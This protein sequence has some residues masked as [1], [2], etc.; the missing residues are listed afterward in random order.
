VFSTSGDAL[1]IQSAD[2][3]CRNANIGSILEAAFNGGASALERDELSFPYLAPV[4]VET[5]QGCLPK[6]EGRKLKRRQIPALI[7]RIAALVLVAHP[8]AAQSGFYFGGTVAADS[9]DRGSM[10]LRTVPAAGGLV[11]WRFNDSW[12]IEF[13]LD[14]GLAE[15]DPH[16]RIGFFGTDTLKDY[17][18]EGF[19]VLATWKSRPLGRV[20]LAASMG[21]SERRFRTTRTIGIDRPVNLPPDDPLLQNQTGTT[22]AAGPTGGLL[23]PIALGGGWS[24]VPELRVGFHFTSEGIYDPPYNRD[25]HLPQPHG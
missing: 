24:V 14:R 15:G 9:A 18:R 7:V 23:L 4:H 16:G 3:S 11:G 20:A 13:H 21:L 12:S 10:D 5:Q 2:W 19:A 6:A 25:R 8:A 22:Q 1:E 17:A